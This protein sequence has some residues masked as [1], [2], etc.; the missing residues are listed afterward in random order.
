MS[1]EAIK[2]IEYT[3]LQFGLKRDCPTTPMKEYHEM[4]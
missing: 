2:T 4:S 1:E 3:F